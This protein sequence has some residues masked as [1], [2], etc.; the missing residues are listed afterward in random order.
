MQN[1]CFRQHLAAECCGTRCPCTVISP[2]CV[3]PMALLPSSGHLP[4]APAHPGLRPAPWEGFPLHGSSKT[5]GWGKK[6]NRQVL[7]DFAQH[8][9][10]IK[11]A[12]HILHIK[13]TTLQ[14]NIKDYLLKRLWMLR[15]E[16]FPSTD[17]PSMKQ[18]Q[19]PATSSSW[20]FIMLFLEPKRS[21]SSK[22][23][24]LQHCRYGRLVSACWLRMLCCSEMACPGQPWDH[25]HQVTSLVVI[26]GNRAKR[27]PGRASINAILCCYPKVASPNISFLLPSFSS[28]G[29]S[30]ERWRN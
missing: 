11:K 20:C 1:I 25:H 30:W 18:R 15:W 2:G 8:D 10:R 7:E 3:V 17:A 12:K 16:V 19:K 29:C 23:G 9:P 21:L 22:S 6:A 13:T 28:L 24:S 5:K 14:C 4:P 27:G 26:Y